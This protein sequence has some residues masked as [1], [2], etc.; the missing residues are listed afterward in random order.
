MSLETRFR[1]KR[2]M[3]GAWVFGSLFYW[4]RY[5]K[6]IPVIGEGVQNGSVQG[7]EVH[8]ETVGLFTGKHDKNGNEIYFG[9]QELRI[10][11]QMSDNGA[12][13]DAIFKTSDFSCEG[14]SLA[15]VRLFNEEPDSIYNSFPI[16]QSLSFKNGSLTIDHRNSKFENLAV[17]ETWSQNT[18]SRTNRQENHY[19]NDIEVLVGPEEQSIRRRR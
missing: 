14:L 19:S 8:S 5:G 10:K 13:Y 9:G 16:V 17:D 4:K 15:F 7:F 3:D 18:H 1:G 2:V 6:K 11:G 12:T